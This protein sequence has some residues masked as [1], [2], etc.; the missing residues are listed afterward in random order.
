MEGDGKS[1]FKLADILDQLDDADPKLIG[2]ILG[3]MEC[4]PLDE[5]FH[6]RSGRRKIL[7]VDGKL[8]ENCHYDCSGTSGCA[9]RG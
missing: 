2:R 5:N 7:G 6:P 4:T 3:R 8:C 9:R 1:Q